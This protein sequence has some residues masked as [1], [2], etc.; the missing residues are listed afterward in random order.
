MSSVKVAVRVRPFNNRE[1]EF[2]AKCV[3]SMTGKTTTISGGPG[4]QAHNF[5]YDYSYWSMNKP[6][7]NFV[8]Q[9][10]VYAE[11][12][13]EM[14]EHAFQGYNVCIF[15]YGQTG[16]GKSYTMMGKPNDPDEMGI[17]PR[18][19]RDLYNRV[20]QTTDH[21]L[22]YKVEVSY[23][24]IYCEKVR[25]LLSRTPTDNLRVR[26][27][28]LFGPYVDNLEKMAAPSYEDIFELMDSGNKARTVAAT[29]M[30]ST[31]SRS[32][33]VFTIVLTQK[34]HDEATN[35]DCEK[36]SKISLVDL[37]GSERA[38][39]TG[40]EGQRLKEGA[41]INKSLTTLGLV[42]SKL[43]EEASRKKGK[44]GRSVVPYRDS[45]LTWLLRE[46]LGGNSKTA[47]IAALSPADIN[48]DETLSTLRYA[49]RAKQIVCRAKVNEDPNARLIREL[50]EEVNRLK[51]I[52][53]Q[54]GI[55]VS[56]QGAVSA[57]PRALYSEEDTIEQL[58]TSEKLIAQLNEPWESKLRKT[59]GFK[60]MREEELRE[61]GLATSADG[62]AL[63]VFSPKKSPHLVNLNE[64]PLMSECL[65]YYLKD[66]ITRTGRPE[67]DSRPDIP[68][69]GEEILDQHCQFVNEDGVV[70]LVPEPGAKCFV[71][72]QEVTGPTKLSTGSRVILGRHHVFRYNDP[73]E[74]RQSRYNL[75]GEA[76][77]EQPID[78][79]YAQMELYEKQGIDL[80]KEMERKLCDMEQ[81]FRKEMEEL[82]RQHKRKN[83]EYESRIES[84][85]RQVDLAQ[86]MISSG[87]STW[88][89][90]G[91]LILTKSL[92]AE[93][94]EE[95]WT[96]DQERIVRRAALKWRYHQF[97]S[98]RDDLWG[99]AIFLKEANA[100][101]V[102]LRKRVQFQFCLL[103]DTMYSPLPPDLLPPGEDLTQRPHPKTVVAIQVKD[104]KNGAVHYW[105][106][107]KL[108]QRLE[109]MRRLYNSDIS[110]AV[111][112]E[113]RFANV[114]EMIAA[115]VVQ[116]EAVANQLSVA[117]PARNRLHGMRDAYNNTD[118]IDSPDDDVSMDVWMGTDPFYDR[119]PWFRLVGRAFVY[120][121][122]LLH[123]VP[124]IHKVAVVNESGDVKGYLRVS[125]EPILNDDK[126]PTKC[127]VRQ[128]ARLNFRKEDFMKSKRRQISDSVGPDESNSETDSG[129]EDLDAE[130]PKHI[131]K[132]KE[133]SFKVTVIETIDIPVHYTDVFCQFNFLHR[134]DEAF[135]TEPVHQK[136]TKT[137]GNALKFDH[138]Q[139]LRTTANSAFV[140]YLQ[141][142]PVIFEIFG[143]L[144]K[145]ATE[146]EDE[147]EIDSPH[148]PL[149]KK[150][151]SKLAYQQ[152]SLAISTPVKSNRKHGG[153]V[154]A[155]L[156]QVRQ[157]HDLLVWF[158]ICELNSNGEYLP[159]VVDHNSFPTHGIFL[160]HQGIQRRIKITICQEKG[161]LR[162]RDCQELVV[163]RIR[164]QVEWA[165]EDSD[166]LSLGLFPGNYL[167]FSM[168]D[169]VFFQFEAAWD[170]SLHNS[171]LLNRVSNYGEYVYMTLSAYMEV[172]N[173]PH[174]A[175]ITK[176][177]C[178]VIYARDSKISAA[179]RF[180]RSLMGSISKS[181]EMNRVPGI[182]ML[183]MKELGDTGA[184]R[185]QRRVLDTS[186]TYVRGEENLGLW[187]PRGDS[188]IFEHQ[189][190]LEKLTKLQQ[191]ERFRLFL[192]LR[193]KLKSKS[194][195]SSDP[196]TPLSPTAPKC[197]IPD[198]VVLNETEKSIAEKVIRLI[199]LKIPMNKESPT[200]NAVE[201]VD[202]SLSNSAVSPTN[203]PVKV[204][205]APLGD[206]TRS[207]SRSDHNLAGLC[208]ENDG[209]K[210]SVSGSQLSQISTSI[211]DVTEERV[212]T[213]VSKKGEMNFLEE[214]TNG[215][216]KRYVVIRRPYI[217]LYRDSKDL[218]IRG[219]INL[220]NARIE[221]SEDQQAML[222]VPNTFS[223]CTNHRAFLMQTLPEDDIHDWLYAINPLMAGQMRCIR[224]P[225]PETPVNGS[226]NASS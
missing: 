115:M 55:E 18:L 129:V 99:N 118:T 199:K 102:E 181:P 48:F 49:D 146:L 54:R 109:D 139:E 77:K 65:L 114:N 38:N 171:P 192:R 100:I 45:V 194:K 154:H 149:S 117:D 191:V 66:G 88:D 31:S 127:G 32:H 164:T 6:D 35:L 125:I 170:S 39:S 113:N 128:S 43:A 25:D 135:S 207:K 189:W 200:G 9:A 96:P 20:E 225:V 178:M 163:G 187:R 222:K 82:E 62:S 28:P 27:H 60:K 166:V 110:E 209:M 61:M 203:E 108:K 103:T 10:Q 195:K 64:D 86:S 167:E 176:D 57:N 208:V 58:K 74:A 8:S 160:L 11:L 56:E 83:N 95:R 14:L 159:A 223:V 17:I 215:W 71:N 190:E 84:L 202:S 68:L 51:S 52:L 33:A 41:N 37:A 12:G 193:H 13:V 121:S 151:S 126:K 153:N 174:P 75:A 78:W 177:L 123:N 81:Q 198:K 89:G 157:K 144:D 169:R 130:F 175:V 79:K 183:S 156:N 143:H 120:M 107:E 165:G 140:H 101:A 4:N 161:D 59:E 211:P 168:D 185:R 221:Y 90:G 19:C 106:L 219:V 213:V 24:E 124:L 138:V 184:V 34:F 22:Q 155:S 2:G 69:S 196:P 47:M 53:V 180:C 136:P 204:H 220:A 63:G 73:M 133:F 21:N 93:V 46:N 134:H 36:V 72:G 147:F 5:N 104:L 42:I 182:Y 148:M 70:T 91:D 158:E 152:P 224:Q 87:C 40:A 214:K 122:N 92:L 216:I 132:D 29:N 173:S 30:N 197:P 212:S 217:L 7:A 3:I 85:Q 119:F 44:G 97:T 210:R 26:E 141:H 67:A 50:K 105:S 16:S 98:V 188:L 142:F 94:N 150:V 162:W 23:M 145:G 218:V 131:L 80:K 179:S 186:S 112:P 206:L 205:A 111:T 172:E 15:A 116:P 76:S 201:S 137:S 1:K 226:A